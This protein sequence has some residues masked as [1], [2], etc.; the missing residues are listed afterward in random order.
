EEATIDTYEQILSS[1][2]LPLEQGEELRAIISDERRHEKEIERRIAD[3]RVAYL[4]AAVLGLNDALIELTGGLTGLVS[5]VADTKLIGF[6]GLVIGVAAALSMA[7][8]NFLSSGM[9]SEEARSGL[10]PARA[11]AYTGT[12]YLAVVVALVAPFFLFARRSLALGVTWAI[13]LMVIAG[14]AFY[15]ATLQE[16]SFRRRFL[17]MMALGLGVAV[18]TFTIGRIVS[19]AVGISA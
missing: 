13:A 2:T 18:I 14:F 16:A 19:A 5:S 7:A 12:A 4:G 6:T 1:G 3:E 10:R 15:S 8:S 9:S 11:A 17:Q